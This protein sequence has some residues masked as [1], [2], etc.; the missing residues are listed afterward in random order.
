MVAF[1]LLGRASRCLRL[2]MEVGFFLFAY[3]VCAA[4]YLLVLVKYGSS[5]YENDFVSSI[6]KRLYH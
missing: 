2:F 3:P 6:F 4:I 5:A 1:V